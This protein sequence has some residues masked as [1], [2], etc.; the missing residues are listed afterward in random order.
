MRIGLGM[1]MIMGTEIGMAPPPSQTHAGGSC[2]QHWGRC[3]YY[4]LE[5]Q[6]HLGPCLWMSSSPRCCSQGTALC[7]SC[8]QISLPG[9]HPAGSHTWKGDNDVNQVPS[10]HQAGPW[11]CNSL[12]RSPALLSRANG[13]KINSLFANNIAR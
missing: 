4:S 1:G 13:S 3:P 7:L 2:W 10:L 6:S 11:V 8:S 5:L 9:K 12:A